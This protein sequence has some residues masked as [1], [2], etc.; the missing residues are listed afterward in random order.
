MASFES[1]TQ[2]A[3]SEANNFDLLRLVLATL[4]IFEH[5]YFLPFNSPTH[6]PLHRLSGGQ[7][8]FGALAVD[9]FFV[10]S[11]FLVTRS[12]MMTKSA[13][14]YFKKRSARILPGFFTASVIG[15]IVAGLSA[16]WSQFMAG[17]KI[18]L[19][20]AQILT[21]HQSEYAGAFPYN[22]MPGVT[23]GTLWSIR[24]EFD[25]Y[26]AVAALGLLGLLNRVSTLLVLLLSFGA[27]IA[28]RCG[29]LVMPSW[30]HYGALGLL[31]SNPVQWPRLV[32]FFFAGA[33]FYCW[34]ENIPRTAVL[35]GVALV[36][37]ALTLR[38]GG[39]EY[40]LVF[41][42]TYCVFFFALSAPIIQLRADISYGLYLFGF[43][44]QQALIGLG[45][46]LAP[47]SLFFVSLPMACIIAFLSWTFIE[48]PF[49][50]GQP[51]DAGT[52]HPPT[53]YGVGR[54][55][56]GEGV[57]PLPAIG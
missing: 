38:F 16:D 22:P 56:I 49:C 2:L 12:W 20:A 54:S 35:L 57:P 28:Q 34:R 44:I 17:F 31:V 29:Y 50:E 37:L 11:G 23:M 21:L 40:A 26:I 55:A 32:P 42:G 19:T 1:R 27:L 47:L 25:C 33:A 4:V 43:P 46:G 5:A 6:E 51:Q 24:Y 14:G 36:A 52:P 13:G 45:I 39:L 8:D 18:P 3:S 41:A 53:R 15:I 10:V 7:L 48:S 30:D 9:F